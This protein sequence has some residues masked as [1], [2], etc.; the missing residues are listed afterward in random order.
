MLR[1]SICT[2]NF[3]CGF[4]IEAHLQS[5]YSQFDPN[6]FEYIVVDNFSTDNSL[7][8]FITYLKKYGNIR[9]LQQKCKRGEGRNIAYL[10]SRTDFIVVVDTDTI[11]FPIFGKFVHSYL[12]NSSYHEFGVRAF[13][14]GIYS[15][16]ILLEVGGW[17][18]LQS[19]DWDMILKILKKT[20]RARILPLMMGE[21][22]KEDYALADRDYRS[23]RYSPSTKI[24]RFVNSEREKLKLSLQL[25]HVNLERLNKNLE[26]DMGLG[27]N[28][29]VYFHNPVQY[30]YARKY[31]FSLFSKMGILFLVFLMNMFGQD[32]RRIFDILSRSRVH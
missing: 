27:K 25:K 11:Y 19:D 23:G 6:E 1:F 2:T 4:A 21:N 18:N 8:I 15:K 13:F 12:D 31:I 32:D 22:I 16:K 24:L 7:E 20:G 5:I 28:A 29:L 30:Q 14:A 26:I 17:N 3:N 10:R 9:I